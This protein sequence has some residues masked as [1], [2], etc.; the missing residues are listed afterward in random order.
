MLFQERKGPF[1]GC[2][3][4]KGSLLTCDVFLVLP[5]KCCTMIKNSTLHVAHYR[6]IAYNII[7]L[8]VINSVPGILCNKYFMTRLM[9]VFF[10]QFR[11]IT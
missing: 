10:Q 9:K 6:I 4:A 11:Y 7:T 1:P 2:A 5:L 3:S 8:A